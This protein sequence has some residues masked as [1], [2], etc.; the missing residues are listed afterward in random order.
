M[1][2]WGRGWQVA[3]NKEIDAQV[4]A[5]FL[6]EEVGA[7]R[8][9]EMVGEYQAD[10]EEIMAALHS[11]TNA[12]AWGRTPQGFDYWQQVVNNLK[13][14]L[15]ETKRADTSNSPQSENQ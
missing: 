5:T 3:L 7:P 12:F 4:R 2:K 14:L 6:A 10:P 13:S 1:S 8:S 9:A 15:N 11:V